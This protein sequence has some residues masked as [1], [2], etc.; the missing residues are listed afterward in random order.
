M[1]L[2]LSSSIPIPIPKCQAHPGGLKHIWII[3][4]GLLHTAFVKIQ[5]KM[6]FHEVSH[7]LVKTTLFL[8]TA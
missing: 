8:K 6:G 4:C 2:H 5:Q 7:A 3:K 1:E